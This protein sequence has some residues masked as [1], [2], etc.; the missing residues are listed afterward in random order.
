MTLRDCTLFI[1]C[2]NGSLD[3]SSVELRLTDLDLKQA[4]P[5]KV[6]KWRRTEQDLVDDGWYM[7]TEDSAIPETICSLSNGP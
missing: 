5:D 7:N 2:K 6:E 1:R 3:P 4:H